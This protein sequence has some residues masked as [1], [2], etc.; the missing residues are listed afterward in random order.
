M[1]NPWQREI[2]IRRGYADDRSDLIRLAALDGASAPPPAPLLV[3]ELDGELSVAL[4]LADGSA[5]ADPFK[6][7]AQ[8]V[9]LLRLHAA[10][11][12]AADRLQSARARVGRMLAPMRW[13]AL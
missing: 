4:S 12:Q 6:S 13:A 2:L 7:T 3:A 9:E 10:A 11:G 8:V 5:I 1:I